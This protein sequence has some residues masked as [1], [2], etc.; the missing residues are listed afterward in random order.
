MVDYISKNKYPAVHLLDNDETRVFLTQPLHHRM[1]LNSVRCS[2]YD[3]QPKLDTGR[4][5][6]LHIQINGFLFILLTLIKWQSPQSLEWQHSQVVTKIDSRSK[7]L[8]LLK[9]SSWRFAK[10]WQQKV[11]LICYTYKL[12]GIFFLYLS[13]LLPCK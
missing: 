5:F 1:T 4:L 6:S 10:N 8:D 7:V 13:K 12:N 3:L 11:N 2:L 9:M